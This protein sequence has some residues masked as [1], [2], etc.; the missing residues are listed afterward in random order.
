MLGFIIFI[1]I[2]FFSRH[3][4]VLCSPFSCASSM[5]KVVHFLLFTSFYFFMCKLSITCFEHVKSGYLLH[6]F[7]PV[8]HIFLL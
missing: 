3:V 4:I 2:L 8:L 1:H 5:T 7:M 6:V